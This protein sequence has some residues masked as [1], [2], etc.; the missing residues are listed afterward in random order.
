MIV[1][2]TR[3][4]SRA[5]GRSRWICRCGLDPRAEWRQIYKEAW[6]FERDYLY[7]PNHH[8]AD[9]DK[10]WTMYEPW[11]ANLGHRSDLTLHARP[12]RR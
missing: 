6:A 2:P 7:V 4:P 10:V 12:A 3:R 5:M 1:A 9:W 11:L 8:G